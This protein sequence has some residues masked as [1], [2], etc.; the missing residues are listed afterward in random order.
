MSSLCSRFALALAFASLLAGTRAG[1]ADPAE[2]ITNSLGMKLVLIP[3][4]RS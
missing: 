4:G 3:S 2:K 1:A